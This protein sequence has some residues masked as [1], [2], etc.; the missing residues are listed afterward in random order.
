MIPPIYNSPRLSYETPDCSMPLTFDTYSTCSFACLYCF[1][2]MERADNPAIK[3]RIKKYPITKINFERVKNLFLGK[4]KG[5]R[6]KLIYEKFIKPKKV[7]QW[8][9]LTEPF[10]NTELKEKE[11]LKLVKFFKEI[12]YPIRICTK[13]A[14]VLMQPE[15]IEAFRGSKNFIFQWTIITTDDEMAK[16]I[17]VGAPVSSERFKAMKFYHDELGIP[18]II[19]I[20]PF[21]PRIT[22]KCWKELIIKAKECGAEAISVEWLCIQKMAG[23]KVRERYKRLSEILGFDIYEYYKKLSPSEMSYMR[24]NPKIKEK[25]IFAMRDLA[26]KLGMRFAISDPHFKHLNDTLSCCGLGENWNFIV[27]VY[28]LALKIAQKKGVVYWKDVEKAIDWGKKFPGDEIFIA[29][30]KDVFRKRKNMTI[31]DYIQFLW[32][33]TKKHGYC[34]V[35]YFSNLLLPIGKDKSGNLI[36]KFNKDFPNK[37]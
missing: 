8:G 11:S 16:K 22:D 35:L 31:K 18:Q 32:N 21:I 33:T 3:S 34:P 12:N 19:R 13:G 5:K 10:D 6:N 9:G 15:Y 1:S 4:A 30:K 29:R 2:W 23:V 14:K 17:E 20:R 7:V 36:Y 27:P 25:Y 26:H 24:L 37:I 28:N